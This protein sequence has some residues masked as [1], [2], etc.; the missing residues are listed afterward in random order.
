MEHIP[1]PMESETRRFDGFGVLVSFHERNELRGRTLDREGHRVE[2]GELD[3]VRAR[4]LVG[5]KITD[6]PAAR[7]AGA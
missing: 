4:R 5:L 7:R 6:L 3:E 1:A 2:L